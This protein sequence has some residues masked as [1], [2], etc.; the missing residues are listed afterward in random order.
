MLSSIQNELSLSSQPK[1]SLPQQEWAL[2]IS[3]WGGSGKTTFLLKLLQGLKDDLSRV[4][5]II[6]ERSRSS[7]EIDAMKL[8]QSVAKFLLHGCACCEQF[9]DLLAQMKSYREENKLV[10]ATEHSPT[11]VTLETVQGLRKNGINATSVYLFDYAQFEDAPLIQRQGLRDADLIILTRMPANSPSLQKAAALIRETRGD[12]PEV[13]VFLLPTAESPITTDLWGALL[14][15]AEDARKTTFT[16]AVE[17]DLSQL[18]APQIGGTPTK[19]E[20][21]SEARSQ[22]IETYSELPLFP[23][24]NTTPQQL[25]EAVKNFPSVSGNVTISR[26]KGFLEGG[27]D[28]QITKRGAEWNLVKKPARSACPPMISVRA[29][30]N[31]DNQLVPLAK[32]FG[33]PDL[34]PEFIRSICKSFPTESQLRA[35][36]ASGR[37][38]PLAFEL[39][40]ELHRL[41]NLAPAYGAIKVLDSQRAQH[42]GDALSN[43]LYA[44]LAARVAIL[45]VSSGQAPHSKGA[46][47]TCHQ[48][49]LD[50]SYFLCRMV[51]HDSLGGFFDKVPQLSSLKTRIRGTSGA[52]K[53]LLSSLEGLT[54]IRFGGKHHVLPAEMRTLG[55]IFNKAIAAGELP[56]EAR[57]IAIQRIKAIKDLPTIITSSEFMKALQGA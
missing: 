8:P 22:L 25:L 39:D 12:L 23:Y 41:V 37:Q 1:L 34:R 17:G 57:E 49:R 53:E 46:N 20:G 30:H 2:V 9:K 43:V 19:I 35:D 7:I 29:F 28:I 13:P 16:T 48:A 52:A 54:Q 45:N 26:V 56:P 6:N 27:W 21:F 11:S 18:V 31:L 15:T 44:S 51:Y 36:F 55:T 14:T 4:G 38:L 3:G 5:A 32:H 10:F 50:A 24:P 40:R 33:T 42:L 47:Q